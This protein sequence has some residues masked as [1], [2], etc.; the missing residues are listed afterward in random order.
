MISDVDRAALLRLAREAIA[1][2]VGGQPPAKPVLTGDLARPGAAFVTLHRHGALRGC[3][4]HLEVDEPLGS[5]VARCAIA[6]GTSDP[7]FPPVAAYELAALDIEISVLG[8]LEEVS[9]VGD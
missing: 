1:A 8:P 4:G 2:R 7:R 6:A 3:I 9:A 5:V